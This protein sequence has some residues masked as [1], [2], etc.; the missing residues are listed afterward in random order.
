MDVVLSAGF[1]FSRYNGFSYIFFYVR[2]PLRLPVTRISRRAVVQT[3]NLDW[4]SLKKKVKEIL[5]FRK[6]WILLISSNLFKEMWLSCTSVEPRITSRPELWHLLSVTVGLCGSSG[7]HNDYFC[8]KSSNKAGIISFLYF[9]PFTGRVTYH[10][11]LS[12]KAHASML[13]CFA[14]SLTLYLLNE[15]LSVC[16]SYTPVST[17]WLHNS[18]MNNSKNTNKSII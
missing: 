5:F 7:S 13:H 2:T 10:I 14:H 8:R 1:C 16:V 4:V 3:D 11:T 15:E 9:S 18:V 17:A 6:I 12:Q